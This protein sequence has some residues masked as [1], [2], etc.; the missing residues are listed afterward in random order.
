MRNEKTN[1]ATGKFHN[2]SLAQEGHLCCVDIGGSTSQRNLDASSTARPPPA[3]AAILGAMFYPEMEED[4]RRKTECPLFA[5][6][7]RFWRE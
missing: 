2:L 7:D 6:H 5:P 3:F 4:D 1:E